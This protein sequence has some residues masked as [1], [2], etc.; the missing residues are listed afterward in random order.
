MKINFQMKEIFEYK[1]GR[2]PKMWSIEEL[3]SL[4]LKVQ[5][6]HSNRSKHLWD[7]IR[8]AG[9]TLPGDKDK[10]V[11]FYR[12]DGKLGKFTLHWRSEY[13][14]WTFS[15]DVPKLDTR[16]E[17]LS[18]WIADEKNFELGQKIFKAHKFA[19]GRLQSIVYTVLVDEIN[20]ALNKKF[21]ESKTTP[22]KSFTIM[23]GGKEYIIITDDGGH[24]YSYNR[25]SLSS[26]KKVI[27]L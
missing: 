17:K 6:R 8:E 24:Y 10:S 9:E 15:W 19:S 20:K 21:K 3:H 14:G 12:P 27:S 25:F 4:Y 5:S 13:G 18:Y 26:E 22:P 1:F 23:I 7:L 2:K 11:Y 16:D